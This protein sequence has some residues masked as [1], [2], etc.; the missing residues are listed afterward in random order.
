[1]LD[2]LFPDVID[3]FI[4]FARGHGLDIEQVIADDAIHRCNV[5]A[6]NGKNDGSYCLRLEPYPVGWIWNWKT[7]DGCI[8]YTYRRDGLRRAPP[9]ASKSHWA[10][11]RELQKAEQQA[12][13]GEARDKATK[14]YQRACR[15]GANPNHPYLRQK[16][17]GAFGI[18]QLGDALVIPVYGPDGGLQSL[19][20]IDPDGQKRFLRGGAMQTGHFVLGDPGAG[21]G[22]I[23][24]AEGYATAASVHMATGEPAVVA[25]NANNLPVVAQLL[26][27]QFPH[28]TLVFAA[29]DDAQT[30]GNP[31]LTKACEAA[32]LV[33]GLVARPSWEAA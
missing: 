24:V 12:R 15:Q 28:A 25:F 19:Q 6:R 26:R 30:P 31:G 20:F 29:D 4:A 3:D 21:L 8:G 5:A 16:S 9:L 17:V 10:P 27:R 32:R 23:A 33:G 2:H 1:M 18:G 22:R 11:L 7:G 13:A 14:L